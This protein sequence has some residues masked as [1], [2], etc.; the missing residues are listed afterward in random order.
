MAGAD[1][2]GGGGGE[3]EEVS[4]GSGPPSSSFRQSLPLQIF[5]PLAIFL[6]V[7]PSFHKILTLGPP[8]IFSP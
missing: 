2:G 4:R 1:G 6:Y 7:F 5:S 3:G 8:Q